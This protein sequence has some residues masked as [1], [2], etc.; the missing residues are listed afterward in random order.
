MTKDKPKGPPGNLQAGNLQAGN[1]QAVDPLGDIRNYAIELW[2]DAGSPEEKTWEDFWHIA[3][4][5]VLGKGRD[6]AASKTTKKNQEQPQRR[7]P[8]ALQELLESTKEPLVRVLV[9][10]LKRTLSDHE[11]LCLDHILSNHCIV[12]EDSTQIEIAELSERSNLLALLAGEYDSSFIEQANSDN[13]LAIPDEAKSKYWLDRL[14]EVTRKDEPLH[15]HDRNTIQ[16]LLDEIASNDS[17]K[18]LRFIERRAVLD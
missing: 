6:Q 13:I 3:E 11:C 1:L 12:L 5:T 15:F 18:T 4:E 9:S 7:I 2:N 16:R 8:D 14:E 10:S 17:V